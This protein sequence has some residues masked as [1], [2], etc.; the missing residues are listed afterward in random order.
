MSQPLFI[1]EFRDSII[2]NQPYKLFIQTNL[3]EDLLKATHIQFQGPKR[4]LTDESGYKQYDSTTILFFYKN[5][6]LDHPKY[7]QICSSVDFNGKQMESVAFMDRKDLLDYLVGNTS[8]SNNIKQSGKKAL[9]SSVF[10]FD[11]NEKRSQIS[12]LLKDDYEIVKKI[13]LLQRTVNTPESILCCAGNRN[14]SNIE[15]EAIPTFNNSF[16]A[17]KLQQKKNIEKKLLP[18]II[19]PAAAQSLLTLLNVKEFLM[20]LVH[21]TKNL[22]SWKPN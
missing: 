6:Q 2:K 19:V 8:S 10:G 16:K 14:F 17:G 21:P 9:D 22:R 12:Q 5:K 18:I 4:I 7:L 13:K 3:T 20:V 15:K 11:L 1:N